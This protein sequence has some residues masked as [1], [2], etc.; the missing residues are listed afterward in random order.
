MDAKIDVNVVMKTQYEKVWQFKTVGHLTMLV[1]YYYEKQS[2]TYQEVCHGSDWIPVE[3]EHMDV[4]RY[5]IDL[6]GDVWN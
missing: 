5:I 4:I 3:D 1:R 2:W 6:E